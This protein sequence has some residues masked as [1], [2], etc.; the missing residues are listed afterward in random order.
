MSAFKIITFFDAYL[1]L[2][3]TEA[4]LF[5]G[6]LKAEAKR[7]EYYVD[8]IGIRKRNQELLEKTNSG[9]KEWVN[10]LNNRF[11]E[12]GKRLPKW[13]PSFMKF[14]LEYVEGALLADLDFNL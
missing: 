5:M 12:V 1:D 2:E 14:D 4:T 11:F 3:V 9:L 13:V 7:I 8:N 6:I 10:Y